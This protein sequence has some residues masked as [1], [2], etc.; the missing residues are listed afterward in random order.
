M[1]S[2]E[3]TN[4]PVW[5]EE[6]TA[7]LFPYVNAFRSRRDIVMLAM[8]RAL[9]RDRVAPG[10]VIKYREVANAD[11]SILTL[12]NTLTWINDVF[13]DSVKPAEDAAWVRTPD[14]ER[15]IST[16]I[17][18]TATIF[19]NKD[20]NS[21]LIYA[22]WTNRLQ[23][24]AA[25]FIPR[26]FP[27]LFADH[28]PTRE[29]MQVLN[30]LL[31]PTPASFVE[32]M[33]A[34]ARDVGLYNQVMAKKVANVTKLFMRA[35]LETIE[36]EVSRIENEIEDLF[37]RYKSKLSTRTQTI[38]RLEGA[39]ALAEKGDEKQANELYEFIIDNPYIKIDRVTNSGEICLTIENY[40]DQYDADGFELFRDN[41]F[42]SVAESAHWPVVDTKLLLKDVFSAD[43]TFRIRT[44]G[45]YEL[46]SQGWV[47]SE[48]NHNYNVADRIPN[49]HLQRHACLG[50]NEEKIQEY[51]K[52]G[53][54][55]GAI[56]QCNASTMSVNVHET[57]ATFN[58]FCVEL[59]KVPGKVLE[60]R[61]G[62]RY[63]AKEALA[64]LKNKQ[65]E[66]QAE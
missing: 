63:T 3:V 36:S 57:G 34:Y 25:Y 54:I 17:S 12:E 10:Q 42:E 23:H 30:T 59:L 43:P 4:V 21:A 19:V 66:E 47:Q 58:P 27:A 51:M 62:T 35:Q 38:I 16:K 5:G 61:D 40:L 52:E 15:F 64:L 1:F 20:L 26:M 65:E 46:N 32:V 33:T 60:A 29:E 7:E 11:E 14:I 41:F 28:R 24:T 18:E 49:P 53:N 37:T 2:S 6:E 50:Q 39:R 48:R 9:L 13:D 55:V 45:Y 8:L 44:C 31:K 56:M 22:P